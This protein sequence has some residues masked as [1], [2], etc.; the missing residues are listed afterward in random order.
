MPPDLSHHASAASYSDTQ[1][2][3][4]AVLSGMRSTQAAASEGM[5]MRME[6]QH[7]TAACSS[8]LPSMRCAAD[9]TSSALAA[10]IRSCRPLTISLLLSSTWVVNTWSCT[11]VRYTLLTSDVVCMHAAVD[12]ICCFHDAAGPGITGPQGGAA[13]QILECI[14]C[15]RLVSCH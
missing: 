15:L 4:Y 13:Q 3:A 7:N 12:V 11:A 6:L 2:H 14:V 10:M 1:H 9:S 8:A 5:S